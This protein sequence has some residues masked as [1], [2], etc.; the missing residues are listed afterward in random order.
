MNQFVGAFSGHAHAWMHVA[1]EK[2]VVEKVYLIKWPV[3][4]KKKKNN[5]C[6][7]ID[8]IGSKPIKRIKIRH[9]SSKVHNEKQI[10]KKNKHM[11]L[12]TS[13]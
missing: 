8:A 7:E 3:S 9:N 10:K 12:L 2:R 1:D 13:L 5:L 6:H 11:S 4:I